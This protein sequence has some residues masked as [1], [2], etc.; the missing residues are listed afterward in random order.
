MKRFLVL[1]LLGLAVTASGC[2]AF[3]TPTPLPT[4]TPRPTF[5][6]GP[7]ITPSATP[8]ATPFPAAIPTKP[9][10]TVTVPAASTPLPAATPLPPTAT[11][12]PA[13][14]PPAPRPPTATAVPTNTPVPAPTATAVPAVACLGDEEMTFNPNPGVV[15]APVSIAVTSA[16]GNPDVV[17]RV[18]FGGAAV[19]AQW[20]AV[21]TGAGKGFVWRWTMTPAQAGRYDANF[22]VGTTVLCTANLLQVNAAPAAT[23][24]PAPTATTAPTATRTSTAIPPPPT[25]TPTRTATATTVPSPTVSSTPATPGPI[26]PATVSGAGAESAGLP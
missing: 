10:L 13:T 23:N 21:D 15:A 19:D 5:T 24:T 26:G 16:R 8:S 4:K 20:I 18:T 6:A 25:S 7:A 11:P 9:A 14:P 17:L 2:D 3:A 12:R 22:Y 1:I